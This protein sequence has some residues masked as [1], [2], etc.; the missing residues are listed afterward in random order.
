MVLI[1]ILIKSLA[2]FADFEQT[3]NSSDATLKQLAA[4]SEYRHRPVLEWS[5]QIS[6]ST[7]P[8]FLTN[9]TPN[10]RQSYGAEVPR[11]HN[12][13]ILFDKQCTRSKDSETVVDL[14]DYTPQL[15]EELHP[16]TAVDVKRNLPRSDI[17]TRAASP[18]A[19]LDPFVYPAWIHGKSALPKAARTTFVEEASL[20]PT[21]SSPLDVKDTF[22]STNVS[23]PRPVFPKAKLATVSQAPPASQTSKSE[24]PSTSAAN[25]RHVTSISIERCSSRLRAPKASEGYRSLLL[26]EPSLN[27]DVSRGRSTPGF[28]P[29]RYNHR[30]TLNDIIGQAA[31]DVRR[32]QSAMELYFGERSRSSLRSSMMPTPVPDVSS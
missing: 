9:T 10:I 3:M 26:K 11:R 22:L 27:T 6:R 13:I 14:R 25:N 7:Q 20:R 12:P 19:A 1:F 15:Y 18:D 28:A 17:F 23:A 24:T 4:T 31:A 30:L 21:P 5:K 8:F 32:A 29:A 2:N 16:H